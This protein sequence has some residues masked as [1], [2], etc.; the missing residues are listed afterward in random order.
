MAWLSTVVHHIDDLRL[1]ARDLR[2][3]LSPGAPVLIRNSF[4]QRHDE[5]MLFHFFEAARNVANTFPSVEEIADTF[6]TT[7]FETR[8]L[9]R[10]REPALP[11]L[12][13]LRDWAVAMRH[14]DSVLAPL[15]D[16]EFAQ[17]LIAVDMAVT[18]GTAPIP[19]GLDLL[20]L[21]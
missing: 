5:V 18:E 14:T 10:V 15:S 12:L 9:M 8:A 17:G 3:V 13:A 20:V 11:S 19:M 21:A 6:A 16:G 4:P 7:G 1:C 2:G